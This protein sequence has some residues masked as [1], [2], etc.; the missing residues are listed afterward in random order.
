M[1]KAKNIKIQKLSLGQEIVK[2]LVKYLKTQFVLVLIVTLLIWVILYLLKVKFALLIAFGTGALSVIPTFGMTLAALI[3]GLVAIIDN[4]VFLPNS[5]AY[6]EG[7]V[8]LIIFFILNKIVDFFL[9]PLFLGKTNNV[10]PF[11]LF[12]VVIV[13]TLS[14][15]VIGAILS[16]PLLLVIITIKKYYQSS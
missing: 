5:S 6:L 8:V 13:G 4:S 7:L 15:G 14:F 12:L 10:N 2:T 1:I 11:L 16:V 3:A 9:A